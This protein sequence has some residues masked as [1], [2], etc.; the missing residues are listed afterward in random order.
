MRCVSVVGEVVSRKSA[1]LIRDERG[2]PVLTR[3]TPAQMSLDDQRQ[4]I[5]A[6]LQRSASRRPIRFCRLKIRMNR[7]SATPGSFS[8]ARKVSCDNGANSRFLLRRGSC[9]RR[10]RKDPA[11]AAGVIESI[12]HPLMR[13]SVRATPARSMWAKKWSNSPEYAMAS[14]STFAGGFPRYC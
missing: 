4:R 10:N 1:L 11:V 7:Q 13:H 5:N 9:W 14:R 8:E 6:L 2:H 12:H 3:S